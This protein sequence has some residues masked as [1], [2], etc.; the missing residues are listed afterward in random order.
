MNTKNTIKSAATKTAKSIK[1][2]GPGRPKYT[3]S[4]PRKSKW[5]FNEF[6]VANGVDLETGKGKTTILTLRKFL[7]RDMFTRAG[8]TRG[9]STI[10]QVK[11]EFAPQPKGKL[12]RRGF[13]YQLRN[14]ASKP[15]HVKAAKSNSV[16]VN[17]GTAATE[18]ASDYEAQKAA[19]LAP[20]A[21]TPEVTP[22]PV[23]T[24]ATPVTA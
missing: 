20:T 11:G 14:V 22:A 8:K 10:I 2:K 21:P 24:D 6:C 5:T 12:G 23:A 15:A 16:S 7:D 13:L 3:P 4:F 19:L 17:V 9:T 1:S 18:V